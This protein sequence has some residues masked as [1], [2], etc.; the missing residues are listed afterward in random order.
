[1]A[2]KI[3]SVDDELD[4]EVLLTQ[5]FR[6]AFNSPSA[7]KEI[8]GIMPGIGIVHHAGFIMINP[9]KDRNKHRVQAL[10]TQ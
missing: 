8:R 10:F 2:V 4:L 7:A 9:I 5:Y 6:Q 3:L 1:M